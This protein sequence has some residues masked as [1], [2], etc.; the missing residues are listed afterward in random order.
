MRYQAV[1]RFRSPSQ[2]TVG[3]LSRDTIEVGRQF[4]SWVF[5]QAD[6]TAARRSHGRRLLSCCTSNLQ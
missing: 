3:R 5:E 6:S 4:G 1:D 2:P